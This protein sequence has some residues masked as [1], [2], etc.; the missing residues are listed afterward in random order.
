MSRFVLAVSGLLVTST[1]ATA[2]PADMFEERVKDFGTTPRGPVLVHYFRLTNTTN[3]PLALGQPRVSCGCTSAALLK[4]RLAPG[5]TTAVVAQ[6]DTRR[7]PTP[8]TVKSVLVYVPF[9]TATPEEVTLKVQTVCR[10]DLIMSPDTL[11]FGQVKKGQGAKVSTKVTFTSDPSWVVSESASTGGFVKVTHKLEA[12]QG[13][14]VTYEVTA[15]LDPACP[16][17]NWCSDIYLKTSNPAVAQLRVPV[18]VNVVAPV[19][20]SPESVRFGDLALGNPAEQRLIMQATAPFKIVR[21]NG[22]DEQIAVQVDTAESKPIHVLTLSVSP[23]LIGMFARNVEI[24]TDHQ[25]Q[26]SVHVPVTA[27]VVGP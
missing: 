27:K 7:I 18:T 1:L 14:T 11:A 20:V 2:G 6:M 4:N 21:V 8:N 24:L 5:E 17:G 16:A 25:E 22:T 19:A 10:D 23:K 12:R 15:Y 13:N 26:P 3:Q 9:L